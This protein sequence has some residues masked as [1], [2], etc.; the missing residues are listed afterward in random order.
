MKYP[1]HA[2]SF[3]ASRPAASMLG[4]IALIEPGLLVEGEATAIVTTFRCSLARTVQLWGT[5]QR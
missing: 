4:V 1:R 2:E 3:G 5:H